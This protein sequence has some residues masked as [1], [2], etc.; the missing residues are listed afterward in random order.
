MMKCTEIL[1]ICDKYGLEC[2]MSLLAHPV[3]PAYN[4]E[5][6]QVVLHRPGLFSNTGGTAYLWKLDDNLRGYVGKWYLNAYRVADGTVEIAEDF[7]N[8]VAPHHIGDTDPEWLETRLAELMQNL[9]TF[10]QQMNEEKILAARE[11]LAHE[12][13][14]IQNGQ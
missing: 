1:E 5:V 10:S 6:Y 14:L 3:N 2:D 9:E 13:E 7:D 11:Q 4:Y 12:T 8:R